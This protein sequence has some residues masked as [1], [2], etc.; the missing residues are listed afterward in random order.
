LARLHEIAR[1]GLAI[2]SFKILAP[3]LFPV[4]MPAVR[5]GDCAAGTETLLR[6][7]LYDAS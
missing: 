5:L 1:A 4:S 3:D 7:F 2:A 6:I